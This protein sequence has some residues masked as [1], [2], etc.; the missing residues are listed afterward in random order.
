MG[1]RWDVQ[2]RLKV[3]EGKGRIEVGEGKGGGAK[4]ISIEEK[5]WETVVFAPKSMSTRKCAP[6]RSSRSAHV[7][8]TM[9]PR[10]ANLALS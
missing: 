1:L 6:R 4:V 9:L 10:Q 2:K 7:T 3:W 8:P 5:K